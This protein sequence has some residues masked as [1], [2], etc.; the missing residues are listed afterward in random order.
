[1][2]VKPGYKMTEVGVIPE[3]WEVSCL[4]KELRE[5]IRNGYSPVCPSFETGIWTLSLSSVTMNGFDASGIKPAPL[6]DRKIYQFLLEEKDIVVSRSNTPDRVGLAGIYRGEPAPCSYPDLLMRVRVGNSLDPGYLLF[7]LLSFS[8]R[9][10]FSENARG[11][12]SSMVKID[13]TILESF[14]I[15]LPPTKSEQEAIASTLSDVDVLIESLEQLITKK[16]NIKQG[17]MQELLTGKRRLPGFSGE[18][19]E[20]S[21][22]ELFEFSG[23]FTA[24][25]DQ[26]SCEGYCYLHYGDIHTSNK[27]FVDVTEEYQ[28]IPKLG[29]E[30]GK[31]SRSSLLEDGDVVF[32]DASEDE[33]GVSRYVVVVNPAKVPFISGLHTIVSKVKGDCFDN[34]Y[35]RYCFQSERIKRQFRFYAVG[36]KVSGINKK[37]ICKISIPIPKFEEQVA[38]GAILNNMDAELAAI[39]VKLSKARHLKQAMM[40]ELL[41]GRIRLV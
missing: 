33:D 26:L 19:E 7:C 27:M 31:V 18:W 35:K 2:E 32:V 34:L 1:M 13:R 39:E 23:G 38:I 16:R 28:E 25:R 21:F 9:R 10:F 14:P 4:G 30:I 5:P 12:S 11:S 20:K 37:S 36:T 29:V 15:P 8:G 22:G 3:D 24:S 41:T 6:E 40:Q 17:A